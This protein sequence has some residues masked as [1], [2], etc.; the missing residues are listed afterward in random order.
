MR[1]QYELNL[2][3][4]K[5]AGI[6]LFELT[7]LSGR[8]ATLR[9]IDYVPIDA[10]HARELIELRFVEMRDEVPVITKGHQF[11]D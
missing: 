4:I 5:W 8:F 6:D 11:L 7:T 10:D 9:R 1:T 3:I 2:P